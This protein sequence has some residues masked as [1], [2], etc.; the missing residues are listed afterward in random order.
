MNISLCMII[1]NSSSTLPRVLDSVKNNG[2]EIIIVDTGSSD[3]SVEIAHSYTEHIYSFE[4]IDDFSAARNF[5]ISKA[6]NDWILVLDSDEEVSSIDALKLQALT[7]K[8][9]ECLGYITRRNH[10]GT[11]DND[12]VYTDEVDRFF[13]KKSWHYE[14]AIHEQL[15]PVRPLAKPNCE[16]LFD[17]GIKCEHSGYQGSEA[18]MLAKSKRN[19]ELLLK[20]LA[21]NGGDPY[22]YFQLGQCYNGFDDK[23]ALYYYSKGLEYD[24]DPSLEYVQMM[25]IAYG[26]AL[27]HLERF[28]EALTL[29]SIYDEFATSADFITLMGVIYMRSGQ[30]LKAMAEFLKAT[31]HP[32]AHNEGANSYIPLYNMGIINEMAG[33]KADAISY[34][35]RCGNFKQAKDRLNELK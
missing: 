2:F 33:N 32:V 34:Y 7:K 3:N 20:D 8:P 5:S 18:D 9:V 31:M 13:N 22:T 27:V 16:P 4:W 23:K 30:Y 29:E 10:F 15:R 1:K 24:V 25:V 11:S 14:G 17:T 12:N 6:T 19:E 35:E 26:Y 21:K 28:D